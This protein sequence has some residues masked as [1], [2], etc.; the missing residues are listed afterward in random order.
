MKMPINE[1]MILSYI[2][3]FSTIN[4]YVLTKELNAPVVYVSKMI[5]SLY[6]RGFIE[7]IVTNNEEEKYI[8]T[9]KIS[10]DLL[11]TWKQ[12]TRKYK[13]ENVTVLEEFKWDNLY[14]P[15]DFDIILDKQL[16]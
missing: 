8:V 5:V 1:M 2:N 12:W 16:D 14:I 7:R 13:E 4:L 6:N 15:R 10:Q 9:D 3:K 11:I